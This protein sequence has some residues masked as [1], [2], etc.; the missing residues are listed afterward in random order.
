MM[1]TCDE[2]IFFVLLKA[3][4]GKMSR[5]EIK[6]ALLRKRLPVN[7]QIN[8]CVST[9]VAP[10]H[11]PVATLTQPVVIFIRPLP[12]GGMFAGPPDMP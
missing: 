10:W 9:S 4:N 3:Q 5:Y 7:P 11:I 1:T 8:A 12:V 6:Q 2:K